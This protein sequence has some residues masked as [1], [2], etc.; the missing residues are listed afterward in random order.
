MD[1][2]D[3]LCYPLFT[4]DE[5]DISV[6]VLKSY[7]SYNK[8]PF[9]CIVP[10]LE[11]TLSKQNLYLP[12]RNVLYSNTRYYS[13]SL[14]A[15]YNLFLFNQISGLLSKEAKK[16]NVQIFMVNNPSDYYI[17][18]IKK[19]LEISYDVNSIKVISIKTTT[20][21][22]TPSSCVFNS[23]RYSF[24]YPFMLEPKTI[25]PLSQRYYNYIFTGHF[26]N[27]GMFI[28][29]IPNLGIQGKVCIPCPLN[30]R[31]INSFC[32]EHDKIKV[33][34]P[35]LDVD[36][37]FCPCPNFYSDV[38]PLIRNSAIAVDY[39]SSSFSLRLAPPDL[40]LYTYS[41]F[42]G[43]PTV[44]MPTSPSPSVFFKKCANPLSS[45][46]GLHVS[47][48]RGDLILT[49]KQ[50]ESELLGKRIKEIKAIPRSW[51]DDQD[52]D[53]V[54]TSSFSGQHIYKPLYSQ[55]IIF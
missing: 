23:P 52:P 20:N 55:G 5:Y 19:D 3:I 7:L 48:L 6:D 51:R 37:D 10:P 38:L 2:Y 44:F 34:V 27:T 21:I 49:R 46:R 9:F 35:N 29:H 45:S 25:I 15:Q 53:F 50:F 47:L 14:L 24:N 8:N 12:E 43:T 33:L 30:A 16:F 54:F 32:S 18:R 11:L 13:P 26:S 40:G 1:T 17:S 22:S 31:I 28:R 39:N 36:I 4:D 42:T 41:W